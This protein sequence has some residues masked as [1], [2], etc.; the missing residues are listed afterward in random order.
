MNGWIAFN[1]V[2]QKD[3]AGAGG[4]HRKAG[5]N[6]IPERIKHAKLTEQLAL[7]RAFTARKDQTVIGL[8]QILC[9]SQLD[10]GSAELFQ[11]L[12]VFN[13]S[14]LNG[15]YCNLHYLPLSAMRSW[16]SL[17]LMPTIASPRSSES[18]A[19]IFASV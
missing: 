14:A 4:E 15:E 9:F 16:I 8:F 18:S 17:S 13:K 12:F 11:F 7:H 1:V 19:I 6:L 2:G 3:H 10:A 5:E